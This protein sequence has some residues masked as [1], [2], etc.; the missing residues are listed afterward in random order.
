MNWPCVLNPSYNLPSKVC[1]LLAVEFVKGRKRTRV[2]TVCQCGYRH[3]QLLL[4]R[5]RQHG[6]QWGPQWPSCPSPTHHMSF[7]NVFNTWSA[8]LMLKAVILSAG[9][10]DDSKM[11]SSDMFT[12]SCL[13]RFFL[14]SQSLAWESPHFTP[15]LC[16]VHYRHSMHYASHALGPWCWARDDQRSTQFG[17]PRRFSSSAPSPDQSTAHEESLPHTI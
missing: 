17:S 2:R 15:H 5:Q 6:L 14:S 16:L 1:S 4:W 7:S 8:L 13:A 10:V 3:L 11:L 9:F 12:S